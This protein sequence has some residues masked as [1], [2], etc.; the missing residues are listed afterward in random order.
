METHIHIATAL[1][2]SSP[3]TFSRCRNLLLVA[4]FIIIFIIIFIFFFFP[5]HHLSL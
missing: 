3:K 5:L 4:E 2:A 1:L